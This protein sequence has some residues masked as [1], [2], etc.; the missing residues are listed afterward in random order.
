[1]DTKEFEVGGLQ[2][3]LYSFFPH[4]AL[5]IRFPERGPEE[6]LNLFIKA[7]KEAFY[8]TKKEYSIYSNNC[9]TAAS[10]VLNRLFGSKSCIGKGRLSLFLLDEELNKA[11]ERHQKPETPLPKRQTPQ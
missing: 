3:T 9:L 11:I 2:A 5:M 7:Q 1:M 4:K 10:S 8:F 6:T